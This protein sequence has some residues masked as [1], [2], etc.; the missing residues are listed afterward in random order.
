ML[1]KET[2]HVHPQRQEK[3]MTTEELTRKE[4]PIYKR[5]ERHVTRIKQQ[6]DHWTYSPTT[7][8]QI[9]IIKE[10]RKISTELN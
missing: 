9:T 5:C 1:S 10:G 4:R 2:V 8:M 3:E 6:P 7:D